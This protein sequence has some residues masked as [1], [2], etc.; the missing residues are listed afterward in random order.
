MWH[1]GLCTRADIPKETQEL[2]NKTMYDW[3]E[4]LVAK[5]LGRC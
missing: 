1:L 3:S 4:Y 2:F 5:E